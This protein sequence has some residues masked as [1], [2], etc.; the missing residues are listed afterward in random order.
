MCRGMN[1][2]FF[3]VILG[4]FGVE[5]GTAAGADDGERHVKAGSAEDAAFVLKNASRV[6]VV[7][8]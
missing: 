8:G 1:R 5:G 6:I 2:S 7:P 3:S 4:G